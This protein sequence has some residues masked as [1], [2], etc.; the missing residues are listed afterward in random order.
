MEETT[1]NS[2]V[3]YDRPENKGP[4]FVNIQKPDPKEDLGPPQDAAQRHQYSALA[5]GQTLRGPQEGDIAAQEIV[6]EQA[7]K[8]KEAT[9][10]QQ[11]EEEKK[12]KRQ[13][14]SRASGPRHILDA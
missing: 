6:D 12:K 11:A 13:R 7:A 14:R 5:A 3:D 2:E 1:P 10:Q 8:E 4:I 9:E